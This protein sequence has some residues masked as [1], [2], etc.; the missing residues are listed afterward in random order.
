MSRTNALH[1]GHLTSTGGYQ[2]VLLSHQR[3][4]TTTMGPVTISARR[5]RSPQAHFNT[6]KNLHYTSTCTGGIDSTKEGVSGNN[7]VVRESSSVRKIKID[8]GVICNHSPV[9]TTTHVSSTKAANH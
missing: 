5:V 8:L 6:G 2:P 7:R 1:R 9:R 4:T 3:N